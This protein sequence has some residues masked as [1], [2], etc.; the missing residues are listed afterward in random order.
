VADLYRRVRGGRLFKVLRV[1]EQ[2]LHEASIPKSAQADGG[3]RRPSA[4][5]PRE[6]ETG[7]ELLFFAYRDFTAEADAMLARYGFGRAHHR[8]LHF[9]GRHPGI[10]VSD[11][12]GILRI[13]KQSLAPVLAQMMREGFIQQRADAADRRRRRL[14]TTPEAAALAQLLSE[15]QAEHLAAAFAATGPEAA[16]GFRAVL[17]AMTHPDDRNRFE[18]P[19]EPVPADGL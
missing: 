8:V 1:S 13:T 16:R 7:I 14:Y 11:L 15:R 10:T 5:S 6:V 9:V 2:A 19:T 3:A 12:L 18:M 4:F 17:Q